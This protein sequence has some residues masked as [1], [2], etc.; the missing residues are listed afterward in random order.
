MLSLKRLASNAVESHSS[1]GMPA[2]LVP[3]T[4]RLNLAHAFGACPISVG[5]NTLSFLL[6]MAFKYA[7]LMPAKDTT[8]AFPSGVWRSEAS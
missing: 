5:R 8:K 2:S 1:H 6:G 4:Q 7:S 3:K